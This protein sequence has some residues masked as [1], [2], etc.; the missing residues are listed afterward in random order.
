MLL[1]QVR[2][3]ALEPSLA[4]SDLRWPSL[5]YSALP[6]HQRSLN[7]HTDGSLFSFNILLNEPSDFDGGGT[8]FEPTGLTVAPSRRGAAVGHSGQVRHSGVEITRGQRYLLVG[9]VGCAAYPYVAKGE[10]A[11]GKGEASPWAAL[12][13]RDAFAKFG[14]GAWSRSP[15]IEPQLVGGA[16]G[17]LEELD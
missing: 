2:R 9:F 14:E 4:F 11:G 1:R 7:V 10:A 3:T 5:R 17:G 16:A 6:G 12:A 13:A 8:R 15:T